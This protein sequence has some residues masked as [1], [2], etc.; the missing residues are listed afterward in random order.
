MPLFSNDTR[1]ED[2]YGRGTRLYFRDS[3][4]AQDTCESCKGTGRELTEIGRELVDFLAEHF[5]IAP[6]KSVVTG[7][8]FIIPD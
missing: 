5:W 8:S 3:G 7:R 4:E 1:C 6:K 2:C